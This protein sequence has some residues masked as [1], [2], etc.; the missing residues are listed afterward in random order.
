MLR[1]FKQSPKVTPTEEKDCP[2]KNQAQTRLIILNMAI[3][4]LAQLL[5]IAACAD[6]T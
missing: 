2:E 6:I 5:K 3:L 1:Y 4:K